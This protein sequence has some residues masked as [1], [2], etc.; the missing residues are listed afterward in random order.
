MLLTRFLHTLPGF[1]FMSEEDVRHVSS[2]MRVEDYPDGHIFIYQDKPARELFLL[3][4][5]AVK[6]SYCGRSNYCYNLRD[7]K[8]GDFMGGLSLVDGRPAMANYTAHGAVK[9]ASLPFS[10]FLLLYQP[11]SAIGCHFQ[12][13]I[14]NHLAD[15]LKARHVALRDLLGRMYPA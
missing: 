14:A 7:L 5:G 11:N 4:E 13:V 10:A 2:A 1:A 15:D 6:V 3:I 8:A 9:V 12:H